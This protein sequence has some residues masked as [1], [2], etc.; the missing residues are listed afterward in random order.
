[1]IGRS[2]LTLIPEKKLA[3]VIR[4][5][6][7]TPVRRVLSFVKVVAREETHVSFLMVFL[8]VGFTRRVTGL[9]RVKTVVTVAVVFV[10]LLIRWIRLGFCLIKAL[11]VLIRSTFCLLRFVERFSFRFL[12]RLTRRR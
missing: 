2:V 12:R 4:G 5:S 7:I 10:S 6:F 1:M 9:S 11:I 8:S 3:V